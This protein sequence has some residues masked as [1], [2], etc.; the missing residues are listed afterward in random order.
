MARLEVSAVSLRFG[1][2]TALREVSF[3]V[4]DGELVALIGPNGAGKTSL[5]N[6]ISGVCR[7][8][9]GKVSIDGED[10][11]ALTR[12]SARGAGWPAP[13]RTWACSRE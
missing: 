2:V 1:G 13:S 3:S 11:T 7:P 4:A 10:L 5:L 6:C 9:S 8:Q 12:T